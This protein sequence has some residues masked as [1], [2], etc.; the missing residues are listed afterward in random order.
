[1]AKGRGNKVNRAE[2]AATFGVSVVTV[3]A[4]VRNGCPSD[5][6]GAG[7]G[8]PWVFD[9]ADV[10]AWREQKAG[11]DVAGDGDA[12]EAKLKKRRLAAETGK[13][14]LEFA[15]ARG[16]VA[17]IRD[18]ERAQASI[19]ARIRTNVMNVTSRV[20]VQV[21][22]ETDE[23]VFK[24][25]LNAELRLALEACTEADLTLSEDDDEEQG[26]E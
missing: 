22:G 13:A 3:D 15:R 12:D 17:P 8:K 14:E 2:L 20:V 9:T 24:A 23:A 10:A 16:D 4:W 7:K 5:V 19:F 11:D 25:K 18:F 6:R 1:M 21:L 26:A